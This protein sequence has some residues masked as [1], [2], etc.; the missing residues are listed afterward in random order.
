M[1]YR[2]YFAVIE[3]EEA[4]KILN[5]SHEE[6][7]KLTA[8]QVREEWSGCSDEEEIVAKYLKDD[9]VNTYALRNY[10]K[11][12]EIV[13]CGKYF[14]YDVAQ[15]IKE[16]CRDYSDEDTEFCIVKPEAL[17]ICAD[18]YRNNTVKYY[19]SVIR[20]F[21]MTD[22]ECLEDKDMGYRR[23]NLVS[24][25]RHQ[26][27]DLKALKI[28]KESVLKHKTLIDTWEYEYDMFNMLHMYKNIDWDKYY[29]IWQGY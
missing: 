15:K 20:S 13:E 9:V 3:K 6:Q 21:D 25:F 14:D 11:P 1:G 2:N 17:L 27:Y 26:I 12:E 7:M 18:F 28:D 24:A 10:L 19:E 16:D 8:K 23:P 5:L 22:E 4:D 29:L